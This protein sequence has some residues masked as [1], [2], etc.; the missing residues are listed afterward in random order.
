MHRRPRLLGAAIAVALA[1]TAAP[2]APTGAW[3][4]SQAAAGTTLSSA[5]P[6]PSPSPTT[7]QAEPEPGPRAPGNRPIP[8]PKV[9]GDHL[10]AVSDFDLGNLDLPGGYRAPVR[11]VL[12][13]PKPGMVRGKVPL[14]L[15][16]H[17]RSP[18]C[19]NDAEEFPCPAGATS[20]RYDRGM[21]WLADQLARRGYAVLVPDLAP[22]YI[23]AST[24]KPYS[25]EAAV[26]AVF[27]RMMTA[28]T[29]GGGALGVDAK[30]VDASR[31]A[32]I[33]HSRSGL[34]GDRMARAWAGG[35]HPIST[36]L[37]YG[38]TYDLARS[39]PSGRWGPPHPDVPYLSIM[40]DHDQDT[41]TDSAE[42]LAYWIT[43]P[44]RSAAMVLTVPGYGHNY[45]NR[46]LSAAKI[47]DRTDC[48]R[49]CPTAAEHERM[50]GEVAG[51]WL[52]TT[53]R[54]RASAWP[55]RADQA[56]PSRILGL[57]GRFLAVSNAPGRVSLLAGSRAERP[58]VS[59]GVTSTVCNFRPPMQPSDVGSGYCPEADLGTVMT[60]EMPL[61]RLEFKRSGT[62][63]W[64]VP[65]AAANADSVRLQISPTG[66]R[67]KTNPGTP[68]RLVVRDTRG[69][70]FAMNLNP[71]HPALA[72]RATAN[73]NGSYQVG[74]LQVTL[75]RVRGWQRPGTPRRLASVQ[76]EAGA[77]S[78]IVLRSI[79][80]VP[81]ATR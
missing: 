41:G 76:L 55:I 44:R 71:R 78:A 79:D 63:R 24:S 40:G 50:F 7:P 36:I 17:L 31:P 48:E 62:A 49:G 1:C 8:A 70:A 20:R 23:P 65:A 47:D 18:A 6:T 28:I 30:A 61:R 77:G 29:A 46:A 11:G 25:Q 34:V 12:A 67:G 73:T 19:S 72:N 14:V 69:A 58:V 74:T 33:A 16:G 35:T 42:F 9:T 13:L 15:I 64:A 5:D 22:V 27:E 10:V 80:I 32:L 68:L 2:L 45:L 56:L 21:Q 54:G 75:D 3:A 57:P 39:S 52:D 66:D 59:R 51:S 4:H 38:P 37:A 60:Y 53:V 43:A 81:R 26:Q